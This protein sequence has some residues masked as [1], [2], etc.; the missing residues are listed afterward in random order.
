MLS[1][2]PQKAVKNSNLMKTLNRVGPLKIDEIENLSK[3]CE[4]IDDQKFK[5][6]H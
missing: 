6:S 3:E 1:E 5:Y 4:Q 2:I